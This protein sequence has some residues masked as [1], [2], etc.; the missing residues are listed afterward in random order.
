MVR[1]PHCLCGSSNEHLQGMCI[2]NGMSE[3]DMSA[4]LFDTLGYYAKFGVSV[5]MDDEGKRCAIG[6]SHGG[7]ENGRILSDE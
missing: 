6:S 3:T 1:G 5:A 4:T 2:R 7:W